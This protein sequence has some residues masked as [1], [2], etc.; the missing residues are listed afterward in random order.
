L[1]EQRGTGTERAICEQSGERESKNRAQQ[2]RA[3]SGKSRSGERRSQKWA[4]TRSGKTARSA[5][6][7]SNALHRSN[8]VSAEKIVSYIF[9]LIVYW[10]KVHAVR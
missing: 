1:C 4:L 7:R 9:V 5:P 2:S 8:R 3:W 10:H 6:L